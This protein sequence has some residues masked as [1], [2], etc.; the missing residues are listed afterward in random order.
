ME[1]LDTAL[2][3]F[4]KIEEGSTSTGRMGRRSYSNDDTTEY[5]SKNLHAERR[6]R[7][8]LSDR[9]LKLRALVPLI[10]NM[11][12][13]TIIEDA[14]TYIQELQKNVKILQEQLCELEA[15]SSEVGAN[16]ASEVKVEA[17]E[18]MKES[19]IQVEA[20]VTEIDRD[21]LWVKIIFEKKRG[22]FTTLMEAMSSFGFEFINTN[23][24]TFKG[25]ML[26]S[27]CVKGIYGE[28]LAVQ[29]ARELLLEIIN[30][31]E[32]NWEYC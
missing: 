14:I 30:S 27:S 16:P 19:G 25:A 21:K 2:D 15:S 23:V 9:L 3:E 7:Q 5:K 10:T 11:N 6:R 32:N 22:G 4:C 12:K 31:V 26:V 8:K 1:H 20:E 13:A 29:P 18:E 28:K 17:A 24:T